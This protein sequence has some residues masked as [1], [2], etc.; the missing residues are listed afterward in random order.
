MIALHEQNAALIVNRMLRAYY[1][2]VS[3]LGSE[4][5]RRGDQCAISVGWIEESNLGTTA[6]EPPHDHVAAV[7]G[8]AR[9]KKRRRSGEHE[10]L[11]ARCVRC[12][13]APCDCMLL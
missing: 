5:T 3:K 9:T 13:T 8:A 12:S 6:T 1:A 4:I 2:F 7:G 10:R 11:V